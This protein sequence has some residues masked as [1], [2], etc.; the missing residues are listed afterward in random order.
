MVE[1][2]HDVLVV[3]D[4]DGDAMVV[5]AGQEVCT[6]WEVV[7]EHDHVLVVAGSLG[8]VVVQDPDLVVDCHEMVVDN[9]EREG[10]HRRKVVEYG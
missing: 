7:H 3:V 8:S 2:V 4:D 1:H 9:G 10:E 6:A 5:D